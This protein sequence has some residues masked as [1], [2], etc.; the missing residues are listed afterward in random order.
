MSPTH[1]TATL[2]TPMTPRKTCEE[3]GKPIVRKRL[4]VRDWEHIR[5]CSAACRR[6]SLDRR[7]MRTFVPF[8]SSRVA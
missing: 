2:V 1:E 5:H 6:F 3:C 7:R 8:W 4:L